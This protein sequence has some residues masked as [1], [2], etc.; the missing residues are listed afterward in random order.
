MILQR[1]TPSAFG[2]L[3]LSNET[4]PSDYGVATKRRHDA[5]LFVCLRADV[6]V[7]LGG[8]LIDAQSFDVTR[9]VQNL[10]RPRSLVQ[11][12][13]LS[14]VPHAVVGPIQLVSDGNEG[15]AANS[16]GVLWTVSVGPAREPL[17]FC[18]SEEKEQ[19]RNKKKTKKV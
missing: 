8:N 10:R 14:F 13:N 5:T 9:R 6:E 3:L 7:P 4:R 19:T 2:A 18:A 1:E 15:G 11:R 12:H 16:N 17:A